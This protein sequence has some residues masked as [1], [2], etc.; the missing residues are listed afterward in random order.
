MSCGF[1]CGAGRMAV[2]IRRINRIETNRNG[3]ATA[4]RGLRKRVELERS[5]NPNYTGTV[6]VLVKII[7][8]YIDRHHTGVNGRSAEIEYNSTSIDEICE[9]LQDRIELELIEIDPYFGSI[10]AHVCLSD[11]EIVGHNLV[12]DHSQKNLPVYH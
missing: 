9:W 1:F 12:I 10:S 6:F 11:G 4:R 2:N 3:I 5:Q 8:G 7:D